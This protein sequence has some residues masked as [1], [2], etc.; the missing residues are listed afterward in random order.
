MFDLGLWVEGQSKRSKVGGRW[1]SMWTQM[2]KKIR[3]KFNL[4]RQ[5]TPGSP[6]P[7]KPHINTGIRSNTIPFSQQPLW[8][9]F[10]VTGE[11]PTTWHRI[12]RGVD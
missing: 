2:P 7:R 8:G 10:S 9:G 12:S 6:S 1:R 5:V 4:V 11:V 3:K